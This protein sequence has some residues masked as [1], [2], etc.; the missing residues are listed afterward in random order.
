MYI[1]RRSEI[2]KLL[3]IKPQNVPKSWKVIECLEWS[4]RSK[5][6]V[7]RYLLINEIKN[8]GK[9]IKKGLKENTW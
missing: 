4:G 9:L 7:K 6:Y 5:K 1:Y 3:N 2:A 8:E